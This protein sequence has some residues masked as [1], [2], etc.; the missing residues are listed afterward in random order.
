MALCRY[1]SSISPLGGAS[2]SIA[3]HLRYERLGSHLFLTSG[4]GQG[5]E[6]IRVAEAGGEELSMPHVMS[7]YLV[8]TTSEKTQYGSTWLT[9]E[10]RLQSPE[11]SNDL[12]ENR[13]TKLKGKKQ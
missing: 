9:V 10:P 7:F 5:F 6:E 2:Q 11:V 12:R 13:K 4:R 8:F 3:T 1:R